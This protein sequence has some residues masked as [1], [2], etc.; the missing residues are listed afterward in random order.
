MQGMLEKLV[1]E[2]RALERAMAGES[3]TMQDGMELMKYDDLYTIGAVA[4]ATR[5]KFVGDK[6]TFAS[7]SYLNY[8]NVCAASCQICAFYRKENDN[9]AYTL[10]PEQIETRVSSA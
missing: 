3:L 6:V 2:S 1:G 10:T 8:T 7:S 5:Q 4:D 9:D